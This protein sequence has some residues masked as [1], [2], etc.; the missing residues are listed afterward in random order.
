[1][2]KI[3]QLN[4]REHVLKRPGRY[5][6][7]VSPVVIE[8]PVLENN[9]IIFKEVEY[10]PAL[11]KIIR[12]IIDNSVEHAVET[13]FKAAN[14]IT[15]D[16]DHE[17]ILVT[18]NGKGIPIRN[19]HDSKGN[20]IDILAPQA[21]WTQLRTGSAFDDVSNNKLISQNGEGSTLTNI[22]SKLFIGETDDHKKHFKL[23][24][25]NNMAEIE[26]KV[27][28]ST[29]KTGTKVLFYP[30]LEKLHLGNKIPEIYQDLLKFEIIFLAAT[31]PQ[32]TFHFNKEKIDIRSFR[33]LYNKYF[34]ND[35]EITETDDVFAAF[36]VSEDGYKFIH[37]INGINVYNGGSV[38]EYGEKY[39]IGAL[40]DI[41]QSRK[42]KSISRADIKNKLV[43]HLHIKNM[44]LPRFADQ[45]KSKCINLPG[46]FP[47]VAEQIREISNSRF[48]E[49]VYKNKSI[50]QP[51]IDLYKAKQLVAEKKQLK[52]KIKNKQTSA[53]YWPAIDKNRYLVI[54]EGDSAVGSI[55]DGLG[56]TEYGFFP[57]KGKISNVIKNPKA[58]NTDA[59]IHE[60][61]NIMNILDAVPDEL[62]ESENWYEITVNK[63]KI[64]VNENDEVLVNGNWVP[65]KKMIKD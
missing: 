45:I 12:E 10:V 48:I 33:Q 53:K 24:S 63:Q 27:S 1:M 62:E 36:S 60:I 57:I 17:K 52:K 65:V 37:F 56:R 44:P 26:T 58:I 11:I 42:L 19:I 7:S 18:D 40:T 3:I 5:I 64:V 29:G 8:R 4:E 49:R 50:I 34:K 43:F 22:F 39:I 51:I 61:L 2:S 15:I 16:M 59:E 9:K 32:I 14:K 23:I 46:Q 41:I 6:G 54:T 31:Y 21:A 20:E 35:I 47:R 38:L 55:L 25:K 30:D 28:K 13:Q